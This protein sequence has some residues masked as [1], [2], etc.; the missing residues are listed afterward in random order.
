MSNITEV[1]TKNIKEKAL[2]ETTAYLNDLFENN[3]EKCSKLSYWIKDYINFQKQ[4]DSFKPKN[5]MR[6]ERGSIVKAHLGFKIGN[7]EGGL[8]Y[9]IVIDKNNELNSGVIT[10]I[11]LT[12]KKSQNAKIH[13]ND[14]DLGNDLYTMLNSKLKGML[15]ESNKLISDL[16]KDIFTFNL[17]SYEMEK[18][19]Y[20]APSE[21][22]QTAI[23]ALNRVMRNFD[24]ELINIKNRKK[25]INKVSNEIKKMKFGSIA[26]VNQI[27][28]ISKQRIYDPKNSSG[29]FSGIKLSDKSLDKIDKQLINLYIKK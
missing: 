4:E 21:N 19:I 17:V 25:I 23:E 28:T 6:Y 26:L 14:I 16:E 10:V 8:H 12:S 20:Y 11:P 18:Q 3:I 22:I 27:T 2:T 7:E 9:C 24:N 13:N 29:I 5:L 1:N 15:Q